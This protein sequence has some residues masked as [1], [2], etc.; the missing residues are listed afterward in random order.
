MMISEKI[1]LK[2]QWNTEK[3]RNCHPIK[4]FAKQKTKKARQLIKPL[5]SIKFMDLPFNNSLFFFSIFFL[6]SFFFHPLF[7]HLSHIL[8]YFLLYFFFYTP[9]FFFAGQLFL[10]LLRILPLG[11]L[12]FSFSFF[13]FFFVLSH[14]L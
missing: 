6:P 4:C 3:S 12:F 11:H 7:F 14:A 2:N 10:V 13:F 5:Q 9:S 1:I 8:Y